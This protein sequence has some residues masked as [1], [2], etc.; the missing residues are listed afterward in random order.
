MQKFW[1]N[2]N[3][4]NNPK[5]QSYIDSQNNCSLCHEDLEIMVTP[6]SSSPSTLKEEA[7]CSVCKIK[8]RIQQHPIH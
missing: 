6:E 4:Q 3:S 5:H 2:E 8:A 7:F 1:T